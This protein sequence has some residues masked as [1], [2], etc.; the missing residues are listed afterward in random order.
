MS[1]IT[2]TNVLESKAIMIKK[3]TKRQEV[4]SVFVEA[5]VVTIQTECRQRNE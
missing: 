2:K 3:H 1:Y 4:R 5:I